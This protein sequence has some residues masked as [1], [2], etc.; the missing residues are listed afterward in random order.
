[1]ARV[2]HTCLQASLVGGFW[3]AACSGLHARL[4]CQVPRT[5]IRGGQPPVSEGVAQK[6][7]LGRRSRPR[8]ECPWVERES[9]VIFEGGKVQV[10][11]RFVMWVEQVVGAGPL[12]YRLARFHERR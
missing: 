7:A 9:G 4:I 8:W 1:M 2:V 5:F 3:C 10:G 12:S 6:A 11:L